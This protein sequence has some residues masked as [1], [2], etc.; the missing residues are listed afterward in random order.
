MACKQVIDV[1]RQHTVADALVSVGLCVAP[2]CLGFDHFLA[3]SSQ[4]LQLN[5]KLSPAEQQLITLPVLA[6]SDNI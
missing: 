3:L 6:D 2:S 1:D 4:D 5:W